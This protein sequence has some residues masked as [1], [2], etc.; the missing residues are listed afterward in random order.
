MARL[1]P[2]RVCD[3]VGGHR[4]GHATWLRPLLV[5]RC[6]PSVFLP[7][8]PFAPKTSHY[9]YNHGSFHQPC[10]SALHEPETAHSAV[11]CGKQTINARKNKLCKF[12]GAL[13]SLGRVAASAIHYRSETCAK[14]VSLCLGDLSTDVT[15]AY[16]RSFR[17]NKKKQYRD[18]V[19]PLVSG[20]SL[21]VNEGSGTSRSKKKQCNDRICLEPAC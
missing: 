15:D 11:Y 3:K 7:P 16:D 12:W 5:V 21:T 8:P 19:K 18:V 6:S 14:V 13:D 2:E 1:I 4:F 20:R 17:T 9:A 10:M